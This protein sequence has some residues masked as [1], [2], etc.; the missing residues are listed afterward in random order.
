MGDPTLSFQLKQGF[1]VLAVVRN[2][3][4]HDT[5]SLGWAAVIEWINA[6]VARPED[7]AGRDARFRKP[8]EVR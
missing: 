4:P 2:Y 7:Y 1:E 3:L 8:V 6:R 5:G